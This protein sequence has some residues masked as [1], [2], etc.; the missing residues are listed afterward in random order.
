MAAP[1]PPPGGDSLSLDADSRLVSISCFDLLLI[2]LVP[3]AERM[4]RAYEASLDR[5][6]PSSPTASSSSSTTA[7]KRTSKSGP[8]TGSASTAVATTNPSAPS[9]TITS[10]VPT[11]TTTTA[12]SQP[13]NTTALLAADGLPST[14]IFADSV[15]V[16][17]ERL[18]FRV[19][20][21]LS[22]RIS[23]DRPRFNNNHHSLPGASGLHGPGNNNVGNVNDHHLDV[24][25]FLCKDIWGVVWRKQVDNLKTN[26]R[27]VFVL[28]DNK[29]RP[30]TRM[31]MANHAEALQRARPYLFFPCGV[32]RGVLSSLG[33]KA[34][35]QA[36]TIELP[37]A[38][39]QITTVQPQI[40]P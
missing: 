27:G 34:T 8:P 38:V 1:P 23:R 3:L 35:V 18:G 6:L 4:A 13:S 2:E 40:R 26:H 37:G 14:T 7:M 28:T 17:L 33:I 21:G 16:R 36:E 31:S 10:A 32:I 22:E 20:E 30:L 15:Y 5:P 25:K 12:S 39:F 9:I 24:I 29:F 19:G 11:T